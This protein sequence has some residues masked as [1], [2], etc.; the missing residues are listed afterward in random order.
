MPSRRQEKVAR[1]VKEAVS[2]AIAHHLNDPRI[3]GFTSV[4][5]IEMSPDLRRADVFLSVFGESEVVQNKT[6]IAIEHAKRRI[7]SLLAHRI[8]SKF[9]PVLRFHKDEEFK[10]TMDTI[11]LINEVVSELDAKDITDSETED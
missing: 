9:C 8:K 10:K 1:L 5:R 3:E 4:T 11:N 2:D 6:I 7:Q